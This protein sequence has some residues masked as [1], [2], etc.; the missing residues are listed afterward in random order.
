M[1]GGQAPP[2]SVRWM[3]VA[4][5]DS[6]RLTLIF[7]RSPPSA[8]GFAAL[9]KSDSTN[10]RAR[11]SFSRSGF[12]LG[13]YDL[14]SVLAPVQ[15]DACELSRRIHDRE[16]SCRE[17]MIAFLAQIERLNPHVNA[18]VSLRDPELLLHEADLKDD[19]LAHGERDSLGWMNGFP[20]A[21]K[22]LVATQGIPTTHGSPLFADSVPSQDAL[23]VQRLRRAGAIIIG[24]TNVPE[25]GLGSHTY[26]PVFGATRNAYA[27]DRT[28]GGSSGGAAV[29]TAVR[30]LPVADGSDTGGSLRNPA[31]YNNVFG[32]RPSLGTVPRAPQSEIFFQPLGTDGP[33][34]RTVADLAQLL[35]V[36]AGYDP[37]AP[38][39]LDRDASMFRQPLQRDFRGARLA[40]LGDWDGYLP[41]EPDVLECCQVALSA[42][43]T[44]GCTIEAVVPDFDPDR[45][46][47][48][49]LVLRQWFTLSSLGPLYADP[50]RRVKMKTE[51]QWEVENALPL[52]AET[53]L[54]ASEVRS[55][56]YMSVLRLFERYDALVMPS[57]QLFPFDVNSTWPR[58][59]NG[60]AM[61]T[62]HRWMEIVIGPTMAGLPAVSVPAGF[63]ASGLPMGLQV[64]GPPRGD[65]TVLQLAHA[66]EQ[67]SR[68]VQRRPPPILDF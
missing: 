49:W 14:A 43:E 35:S 18:I 31:A 4:L 29:A 28:A 52:T 27:Q 60:R 16:I 32:F 25:F 62:Y 38:L 53:V 17:V 10:Q 24:K 34:A 66:Y 64:I 8:S 67:A 13:D 44:I 9:A 42:F 15:M 30:M 65:L 59:I 3:R 61:D 39:S 48:A 68:W 37:R 46:W 7:I 33:L 45:L 58:E 57:A 6:T 54:R 36:M 12:R 47:R 22:D 50:A 1:P 41:V 23:L 51:A 11:S 20:H 26:N 55:A 5:I 21:V 63:N 19:V 2:P 56:W 40:W